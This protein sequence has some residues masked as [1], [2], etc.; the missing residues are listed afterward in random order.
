[1]DYGLIRR[2]FCGP[3]ENT[4]VFEGVNRLG[5]LGATKVATSTHSLD[6]KSGV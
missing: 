1:M 2:F 3:T 5:T 4:I 6:V